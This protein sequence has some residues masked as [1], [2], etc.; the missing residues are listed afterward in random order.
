MFI[1][2]TGQ[3]YLVLLVTI[4][5]FF[6]IKYATDVTGILTEFSAAIGAFIAAAIIY[7]LHTFLEIASSGLTVIDDET[8]ESAPLVAR[9]DLYW[10]PIKY[11]SMILAAVGLW[12]TY[13]AVVALIFGA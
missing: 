11:W 1:F 9:H 5:S 3:G 12:L 4:V 6:S 2:W 10:I 8:G 7:K 13:N